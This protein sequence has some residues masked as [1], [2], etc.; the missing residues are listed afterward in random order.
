MDIKL[1]EMIELLKVPSAIYSHQVDESEAK[2]F[3]VVLRNVSRL[4]VYRAISK[5]IAK[6][7]YFP[8]PSELADLVKLDMTTNWRPP[9][10]RFDE[11]LMWRIAIRGLAS[12]DEFS[13]GFPV[14]ICQVV[15]VG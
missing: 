8:R 11:E 9:A 15:L 6:S 1:S 4:Q 10:E 3:H 13:V 14:T 7:K 2:G 12:P 5:H